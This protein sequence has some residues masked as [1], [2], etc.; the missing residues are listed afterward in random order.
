MYLHSTH[1]HTYR[2]CPYLLLP[3]PLL[4]ASLQ[5]GYDAGFLYQYSMADLEV[6]QAAEPS[7]PKQSVPL[8]P[9]AGR[10]TPLTALT[11]RYSQGVHSSALLYRVCTAS[12]VYIR[13]YV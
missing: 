3:G 10:D 11:F 2:S 9:F 1:T 8:P 4:L 6:G 7:E 13:T 12:C 5:G